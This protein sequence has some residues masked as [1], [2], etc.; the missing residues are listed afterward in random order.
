MLPDMVF[1][2]TLRMQSWG[3]VIGSLLF[4]IP[5]IQP[6]AKAMGSEGA[7]ITFFVGSWF[8]T[9]A[10]LI[11]LVR[12]GSPMIPFHGGKALSAVWTVAITQTIG[13]LLFNVST[14]YAI[15]PRNLAVEKHLVWSPDAA[16]SVAFLISGAVA[17]LAIIRSGQLWTI[18][19]KDSFSTWAN[20]FGCIAFGLS[21]I[22]AFILPNGATVDNMLANLGTFIGAVFFILASILFLG[23]RYGARG[24]DAADRPAVPDWK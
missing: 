18:R 15:H 12:S 4:A 22:G 10:G 20:L 21:A 11:Q 3:F 6:I 17:M 19:T 9:G 5:S 13:T 23:P 7:N 1:Q 2:P 16:G 8:F 24:A 14:G